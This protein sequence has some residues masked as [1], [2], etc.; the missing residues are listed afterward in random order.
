MSS[1]GRSLSPNTQYKCSDARD[2]KMTTDWQRTVGWV[3]SSRVSPRGGSSRGVIRACPQSE[4]LRSKPCLPACIL[5]DDFCPSTRGCRSPQTDR[6]IR[7]CLIQ[8]QVI[9]TSAPMVIGSNPLSCQ[10]LSLSSEIFNSMSK[11]SDNSWD[12]AVPSHKRAVTKITNMWK[13]H[14]CRGL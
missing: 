10:H 7:P 8:R 12:Q 14:C 2:W 5:L 13:T 3:L 1:H 4:I 9:F 6:W 11:L